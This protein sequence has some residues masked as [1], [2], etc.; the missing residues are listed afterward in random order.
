VNPSTHPNVLSVQAAQHPLRGG[1]P[2]AHSVPSPRGIAG[3]NTAVTADVETRQYRQKVTV[4]PQSLGR[5]RRIVV[6]FLRHWGLGKLIDPAVVCVSELLANVRA[7]A[8]SDECVLSL[9]ATDFGARIVV[10]DTSSNLP[11]V[12][13]P[14]WSAESGRGMLLIS[15]VATSWGAEPTGNG[16]DVWVE[17]SVVASEE[18]A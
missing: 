16:K 4:D 1:L 9:Q 13:E 7:H 12:R 3:G 8:A 18:A 11:I 10:S 17:L 15:T 14:D 2:T 5:I 6:A